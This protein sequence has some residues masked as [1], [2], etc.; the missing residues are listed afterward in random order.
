MIVKAAMRS[1]FDPSAPE[2]SRPNPNYLVQTGNR[3]R[4]MDRPKDPANLDAEIEHEFLDQQ[5]PGFFRRDLDVGNNRHLIFYTDRQ[6]EL[7]AKA[8]TWYMD[9]TFRVVNNPWK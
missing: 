8:K 5:C 7:L 1:H 3:L 2:A 4:Q 9:G 6:M